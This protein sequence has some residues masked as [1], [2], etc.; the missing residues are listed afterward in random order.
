[1]HEISQMV[2]RLMILESRIAHQDATIDDLNNMVNKQWTEIEKLQRTLSEQRA[3]L[4]RIEG[5]LKPDGFVE[6]PPHY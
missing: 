5:N 4:T 1:M 3:L 6:T 2:D